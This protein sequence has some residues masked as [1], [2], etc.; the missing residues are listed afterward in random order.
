ME[1]YA[2]FIKSCCN[3]KKMSLCFVATA[4]SVNRSLLKNLEKYFCNLTSKK[5]SSNTSKIYSNIYRKNLSIT[6]I[7]LRN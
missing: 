2:M 4:G 1:K 6:D 5:A 3:I 7:T